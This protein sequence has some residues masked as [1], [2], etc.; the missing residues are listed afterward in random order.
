V[1]RWCRAH[2]GSAAAEELFR[3]G[4]LSTVIGI[5]LAS[6]QPIVV[7]VRRQAARLGACS[8]VHRV[9]YERGFPCPEPLVDIEP[10]GPWAASAETLVTGGE[11]LPVSGRGAQPFAESLSRLLAL[12]PAVE[13]VPSL[14]PTLAWTAWNHQEDGL[15]PWPDDCDI[16]LNNVEGPVWVDEAGRAAQRRLEQ[17]DGAL[18]VGHGDWY[19]DNLRWTGTQ[20]HIAFDWDSVIAAPETVIVGLAAAIYPAMGE[21]SEATVDETKAFIDAYGSMRGRPFNAHEQGEA[22]AAGLWSRSFDAKKQFA[23]GGAVLSLSEEEARERCLRAGI[24]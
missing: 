14:D 13:D 19:T 24:G 12:C 22:W 15:W 3:C 1:D 9:L 18:F 23:I 20:L 17:G 16:D 4:Y 2:L 7:K 10:L 5:R 8:A 6:G 11:L 21:G